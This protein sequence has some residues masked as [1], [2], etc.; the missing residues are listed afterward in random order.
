[1]ELEPILTKENPIYSL[2][3][4]ERM[5]FEALSFVDRALDREGT[6]TPGNLDVA[7]EVVRGILDSVQGGV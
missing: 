6:A 4:R 5:M 1:M 2:N 7:R 3:D